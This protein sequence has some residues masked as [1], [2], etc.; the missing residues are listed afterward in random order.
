[1]LGL[2]L[3]LGLAMMIGFAGSVFGQG[4][5]RGAIS[6]TVTDPNGAAVPG[7]QVDIVNQATGVVERT[8]KTNN[9]GSFSA[10][11]LPVGTYRVVVTASGFAK[12]EAPDIRVNVTETTNLSV[13]LKIGGVAETVTITAGAAPVQLSSATTGQTLGAETVTR[14]PLATG[15]FLTLLTLSTGANT[16]LFQSDALG[17]G[18]VTIN[19]N[20]QRPVNNNYQLEG[21]NAN[22]I[23]LPQLDNVPLPNPN[24]VAEFKTQTS[25]YDASQG[26]NGGGN[27]QVAL[28][29]GSNGYHGNLYEFFRNNVLNANDFFNN[30]NG[31]ARPVLRQNQFGGSIGGPIYLP[32]FGEGG[33]PYISGKNRWF[34][35]FNYQGTRAASGAA[36]GTN[37]TTNIPILPANRSEANLIATF[38]PGGLPPGFTHL[39]SVALRLLTLPGNKCPGFGG[40]FCIPSLAGTPGLTSTG[41][42]RRAQI[43]R[44]GIGT[45]SDNQLT[46][47]IDGQLTKN[48][49][50]SGRY[51]QS[52]NSTFQPFGN[53]STLPFGKS[54][55]G[56][57]KFVK[58][59]LTSALSP[60]LVNDVRLGFNRFFFSQEPVEPISLAD[61]GATR[62][63]SGEFPATYQFIVSSA[64]S[65]GAGVNDN[66]GG[67]FNTYVVGDDV[68]YTFGKHQIRAGGEMSRYQ[69]NR[70]NNFAA[71]GSVSF[72]NTSAGAGGAGIPALAGF[73]NFLLGRITAT[74][75]RSGFSTFYFRAADYGAYVQDDWK[76]SKRLTLNLGLR[77][78]GLSTAHEKFNF[79]SN[80]AGLGDGLPPPLKFIHPADTPKVGTPGVT[81]C[82][83]LS[84]FDKNNFAPRV[85][86]AYDVFGNQKTVLRGGAGIYY[87]RVSNQPLL[88]TSGGSPFAED[89]SASAFTVTTANPFPSIRPA[90]DFP[91]ST[92]IVVPRLISFN[93]TTGAPIFDSANGAPLGG[94]RFFPVRNFHAP[95][96]YQWNLTGQREV[97][98]NWV[99]EIGYV[100]TRGVDLLGTGRPLDPGQICTI[101]TPCVIPSSLASSVTVPAGTP[102]VTK[103]SD[104]SI[105]ITQST[106]NNI[107]ARV[108]AQFLGLANSRLFAQEQSSSSIY[109]SMQTS[110]THR[111]SKGL[112]LQAAYTFA[113][114]IDN[115][116]GSS[117]IDELNGLFG[118]GDLT[119]TRLQR[120]LSDFDRK[121]RLVVSY[122]YDVPLGKWLGVQ[123]KGFGKFVN[124]WAIN[125]VYTAQSGTPF[126]IYDSTAVTLQ[127]TDFVNTTNFATLAP[128]A[129]A[130]SVLTSGST[131]SRIDNFV[132][133]DAFIVGGRCVNNQNVIVSCSDAS[134]TGFAAVG[135]LGRNVFRGPFQTNWD[136]SFVKTTKITESTNLEFHAEF[137]DILNHPVFQSP[138]AAG[139]ALGNYGTVDIGGGVSSTAILA[140][141]NRPR[142]IQFALKLNF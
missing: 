128:G 104:G 108:P 69:L 17:R 120:G 103:N 135:N 21:I 3:C 58:I 138:Q 64:F 12:A 122:N 51:F 119:S 84:C 10:T 73:Q 87:Q 23:N 111:F 114:S 85:G 88:Q 9:D 99:V 43:N 54:L 24:T 113:K 98:K 65:I 78:E 11:L 72:G 137:F 82:T 5:Q 44:T 29:S 45:F 133:L 4:G 70:F 59:G 38:F 32:R 2:A 37:F 68:S 25:L 101:A 96:A 106:A 28:R 36:S 80:F 7:A 14:L 115:S 47:S 33:R 110:L 35:F 97:F 93:A 134:S 74:Q 81:N 6:G 49:K 90:S 20:G 40:D 8:V 89:F 30:R 112:Y 127:D 57:N 71:R 52:D 102:G 140:T 76:F 94:F 55:P 22:D 117:F 130:S 42:V 19:V 100:G 125:G 50:I 136:M 77:W 83:L 67:T 53:A 1:M 86:F 118:W 18:A 46:V 132:N 39:D 56:F 13:P 41:A 63:N 75:G 126:M 61:I 105:S 107:N 60:K 31:T 91:L 116:S 62:G 15:N 123:D 48:N 27:I 124:G 109:H 131:S 139:G 129:T 79:L 142:I 141:A 66:R 121:H 34:F 92:D 95:Q 16:E 26:R